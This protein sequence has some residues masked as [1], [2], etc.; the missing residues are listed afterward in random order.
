MSRMTPLETREV[1]SGILALAN[2]HVNSY[3]IKYDGGY[4]AIDAGIKPGNMSRE[5]N[6]LRIAPVDISHVLLTHTDM[7]HA[8]GLSVFPDAA[9]YLPKKE[10]QMI[11]GRTARTFG[12]MNILR[13]KN[14]LKT[15][16]KTLEDGEFIR[17]GDKTIQC[18][19]TPGHTPGSMSYIVDRKYLFSGDTIRLIKGKA[20]G[21][22]PFFTMD[23]AVNA[24][25][26]KRLAAY[27]EI[28]YIFTAHHGITNTPE[29]AFEGW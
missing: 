10:E 27:P 24:K 8:G 20:Q 21:F 16:Y 17:I 3:L 28:A 18:V 5:L 13:I 23:A 6:K 15:N 12:R 2:G 22:V 4:I 29:D 25:S 26:I 14:K 19:L 7:D 9:V 1:I 11:N